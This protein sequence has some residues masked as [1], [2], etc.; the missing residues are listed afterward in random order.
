ML[1]FDIYCLT[2]FPEFTGTTRS[3]ESG[4]DRVAASLL[5]DRDL[6]VEALLKLGKN[7]LYSCGDQ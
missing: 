1:K 6:Y 4:W 7:I 2:V 3:P 5:G